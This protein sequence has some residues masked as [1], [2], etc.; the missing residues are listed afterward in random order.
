LLTGLATVARA[1]RIAVLSGGRIVEEG[2]HAELVLA[3]GT[4]SA[5]ALPSSC[6]G[7]EV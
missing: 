5:S 2:T 3:G 7:I 1:D 6:P 4:L